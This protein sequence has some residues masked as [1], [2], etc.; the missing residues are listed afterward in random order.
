[1]GKFFHIIFGIRWLLYQTQRAKPLL[2]SRTSLDCLEVDYNR[3]SGRS[4][5]HC[6]WVLVCTLTQC[7]V[8]MVNQ[9]SG[10][11]CAQCAHYVLKSSGSPQMLIEHAA[12]LEGEGNN[13]LIH[14][15][16]KTIL[17]SKYL[18]VN[19]PPFFFSSCIF[20]NRCNHM[21]YINISNLQIWQW[22]NGNLTLSLKILA[23]LKVQCTRSNVRDNVSW[24]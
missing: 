7:F 15:S 2:I 13:Y 19:P 1:M 12:G 8:F 4:P 22:D 9:C 16:S 23:E 5:P 6:A 11:L 17:N 10:A 24:G 3:G 14:F 18:N 20:S 21:P